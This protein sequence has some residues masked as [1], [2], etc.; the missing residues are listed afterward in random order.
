MKKEI[1]LLQLAEE[2]DALLPDFFAYGFRRRKKA[3][4]LVVGTFTCHWP[5][6]I[7]GGFVTY[8]QFV[9]P[10]SPGVLS[11]VKPRK[12]SGQRTK[13]FVALFLRMVS[14]KPT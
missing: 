9:P 11:N 7:P 14:S 4:P 6:A 5:S 13:A 10:G 8:N 2:R 12:A 1:P 3:L